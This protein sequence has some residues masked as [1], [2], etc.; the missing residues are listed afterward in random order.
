MSGME[1]LPKGQ[2]VFLFLHG[3]GMATIVV[4]DDDISI[5][6]FMQSAL[7]IKGHTVLLFEDARP[8]LDG[9]DFG[10]VDLV[11]TDLQM[12]TSGEKFIRILRESGSQVPIVVMSGHIQE[13]AMDRILAS[14]VQAVLVKP[15]SMKALFEVVGR[16]V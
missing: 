1:P 3:D 16:L 11:I 10:S 6:R 5:R 4:V 8:A 15:F 14:G 9:V 2:G 12:P 13:S 7:E